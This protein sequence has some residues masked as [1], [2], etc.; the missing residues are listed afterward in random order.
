MTKSLDFPVA[1]QLRD[2]P[3]TMIGAGLIATGRVRQLLE[4]GAVVHVVAPLPSPEVRAWAA[5]GRLQLSVRLYAPGDCAGAFIVF[6]ATDDLE[7]NRAVVAE[8]REARLLVN[9]ADRPELCDFTIPAIGRRGPVVIAVSTG[10]HAP[11]LAAVLRDRLLVV[12]GPQ[13]GTLA[14]LL[15]RLRRFAP[16]GRDR[17]RRMRGLIEGGAAEL[18]ASGD[19]RGLDRLIRKFFDPAP[20]APHESAEKQGEL[21]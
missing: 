14:R 3:V 4:V 15:G 17:A 16:G 21:P 13:F 8:A 18:L 20:T 19:R 5:A 2:R 9:A 1:L 6:T 11:A 12:A 10:G 7:V